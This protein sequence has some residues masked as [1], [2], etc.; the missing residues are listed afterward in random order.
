MQF[1]YILHW[2]IIDHITV[3]IMKVCKLS[4]VS[5]LLPTFMF[6]LENKK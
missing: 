1:I 2:E 3:L 5:I 6:Q 4:I